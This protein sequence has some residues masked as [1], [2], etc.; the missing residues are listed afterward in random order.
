MNP[1]PGCETGISDFIAQG[2]RKVEA[3][4]KGFVKVAESMG[5]I[6]SENGLE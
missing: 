6:R 3:A 5:R 2:I 1:P 4:Y